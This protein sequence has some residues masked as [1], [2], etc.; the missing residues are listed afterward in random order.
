MF[1]SNALRH[2]AAQ[3]FL[4]L[5]HGA[6]ALYLASGFSILVDTPSE[7][8]IAWAVFYLQRRAIS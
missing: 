7:L 8:C 3:V 1:Y 4:V 6:S 5:Y 2:A